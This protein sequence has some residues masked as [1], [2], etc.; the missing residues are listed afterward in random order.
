MQL[1]QLI[2]RN[3]QSFLRFNRQEVRNVLRGLLT[4][5]PYSYYSLDL[6][7]TDT[8]TISQLNAKYLGKDRPTDVLSFPLHGALGP[9]LLPSPLSPELKNLGEIYLCPRY[10]YE[11]LLSDQGGK[12]AS[13]PLPPDA[14]PRHIRRLLIHSICHLI[15]YDHDRDDDYR[16]MQAKEDEMARRFDKYFSHLPFHLDLEKDPC[17]D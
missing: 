4:L 14:F 17:S 8:H 5:T 2:I 3:K 15:G 7:W 9:G 6:T 13:F 11:A 1:Q 12:Q 10:A 16:I